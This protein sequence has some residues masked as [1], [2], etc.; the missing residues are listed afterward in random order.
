MMWRGACACE[1][2]S[3]R[4]QKRALNPLKLGFQADV[5]SLVCM[6]GAQLHSSVK[7]VY[8]FDC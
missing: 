7:A 8:A 5:S 4:S 3:R 1:C 2:T 6:A